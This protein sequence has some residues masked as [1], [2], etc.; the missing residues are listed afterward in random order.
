MN[1]PF[2]L[3]QNRAA[4][5]GLPPGPR[6]GMGV[7]QEI[8]A[9]CAHSTFLSRPK[10][11][12]QQIQLSSVNQ[13]QT[14]GAGRG[15]QKQMWLLRTPPPPSPLFSCKEDLPRRS[16][17]GLYSIPSG[18]SMGQL[19]EGDTPCESS[20]SLKRGLGGGSSR[21]GGRKERSRGHR[22]CRS[23]QGLPGCVPWLS[24]TTHIS[25][26]PQL[27]EALGMSLL[28]SSQ[29][30]VPAGPAPFSGV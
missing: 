10:R 22:G 23:N 1:A 15:V 26:V 24:A 17:A 13:R 11:P 19:Y 8:R 20:L 2:L 4:I 9:G 14:L 29:P 16:P 5:S 25:R 28:S 12:G 7:E 6:F 30:S 18:D 21:R 3:F 27:C